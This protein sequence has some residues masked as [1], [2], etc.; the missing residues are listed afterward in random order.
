M[1]HSI[2]HFNIIFYLYRF[3]TNK[4]KYGF[5]T[6]FSWSISCNPWVPVPQ[7]DRLLGSLD[8]QEKCTFWKPSTLFTLKI[9]TANPGE[10]AIWLSFPLTAFM[11]WKMDWLVPQGNSQ[12]WGF[13][14]DKLQIRRNLSADPIISHFF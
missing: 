8:A 9:Q 5:L 3:V 12:N 2:F 7:K 1:F 11:P 4:A 6:A 13:N 14:S 10:A